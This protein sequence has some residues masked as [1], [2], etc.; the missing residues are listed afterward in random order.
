MCPFEVDTFDPSG[1]TLVWVKV[2]SLSASTE[3]TVYFSG[4]ANQD[5]NPAD[6]WSRYVAVVHGGNS[7]ANSVANGLAVTA[8]SA[9]VTAS[10][11]AGKVGG[12]INKSSYNSIG[13]NVANPS[14]TLANS[15]KFS[16]SA[17]FKRSGNGGGNNGTHIL[18][19]SQQGWGGSGFLWLQEQGKYI[20]V[21]APGSHQWSSG[22]YTL[23]DGAWAHA[24]FV[25]ESGVSLTSYFNGA[26]DQTKASPGNLVN[27][28]A[29]WTFGSYQ[30]TAS[31]DSFKGDMDE[32][33]IFSGVASGDWIALEYATMADAAFFE[34]GDV[35]P[36]D[37]SATRFETPTAV[38]NANGTYTVSV[39]LA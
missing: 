25:Y 37:P 1:A 2:P 9:A 20:S 27:S 28:A 19:A 29:T 22:Q 34:Y 31:G 30:N 11:D 24:A 15:G 39:V 18:G 23:P 21:A 26:Q 16:V 13:V 3:L 5:N 32:L 7:I 33:R 8:G 17:W 36:V 38:R 4:A 14:G 12:G 6:V 35:E 10:A